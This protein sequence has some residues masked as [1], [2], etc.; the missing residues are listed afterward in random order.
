MSMPATSSVSR[1]TAT[2]L[3]PASSPSSSPASQSS[4][5][6]EQVELQLNA[7]ADYASFDKLP[8]KVQGLINQFLSD[9]SIPIFEGWYKILLD[10]KDRVFASSSKGTKKPQIIRL[11]Q[12][13][14]LLAFGVKHGLASKEFI[15]S[16]FAGLFDAKKKDESSGK[17]EAVYNKLVR[18]FK[19]QAQIASNFKNCAFDMS[20]VDDPSAGT[21]DKSQKIYPNEEKH[22]FAYL[23]RIK[24]VPF[25]SLF[26][27]HTSRIPIF[28]PQINFLR[29]WI[30][31]NLSEKN[32]T[33]ILSGMLGNNNLDQLL[34]NG[35]G[36]F[37]AIKAMLGNNE[38]NKA[39]LDMVRKII[40][41]PI[42][43]PVVAHIGKILA[44]IKDSKGKVYFSQFG[45]NNKGLWDADFREAY[46]KFVRDHAP[47]KLHIITKPHLQKL[48]QVARQQAQ[49]GVNS[50][51]TFLQR[52]STAWQA[53]HVGNFVTF[54]GT[55]DFVNYLKRLRIC[56]QEIANVLKNQPVNSINIEKLIQVLS[57]LRK[58]EAL[59]RPFLEYNFALLVPKKVLLVVLDHN[60]TPVGTVEKTTAIEDNWNKI[61]HLFNEEKQDVTNVH[62]KFL[63][64]KPG[65]VESAIE[66]LAISEVLK[67]ILQQA[68]KLRTL[69]KFKEIKQAI[70]RVPIKIQVINA[71]NKIEQLMG[72]VPN[73]Y[74][75]KLYD[76]ENANL[77]VQVVVQPDGKMTILLKKKW[78]GEKLQKIAAWESPAIG[79][80]WPSQNSF[81]ETFMQ[82]LKVPVGRLRVASPNQNEKVGIMLDSKLVCNGCTTISLPT[83]YHQLA[84]LQDNFLGPVITYSIFRGSQLEAV[85]TLP[86]RKA[87]L[88]LMPYLYTFGGVVLAGIGATT[89]FALLASGNHRYLLST[90]DYGERV[91]RYWT[92][93][94]NRNIAIACGIGTG[95]IL[96]VFGVLG[97]LSTRK[98]IQPQPQIVYRPTDKKTRQQTVSLF[99]KVGGDD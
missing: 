62:I 27:L 60:G 25:S 21:I 71:P 17:L 81:N 78:S 34:K 75:S 69:G 24:I 20:V 93:D 56:G 1:P 46:E 5:T 2:R 41:N 68:L 95:G 65:I 52:F 88:N 55:Y 35:K 83:F 82:A 87:P 14:A 51:K 49:K 31:Y 47:L 89:V 57:L 85:V 4:I 58:F 40:A 29:N 12:F 37:N 36:P 90:R 54:R 70:E 86:P 77:L 91:D 96:A 79:Q 18:F 28:P 73:S 67:N 3:V 19:Y 11:I 30:T 84:F 63:T 48:Y 76:H 99:N 45:A 64:F 7:N 39:K 8:Q 59:K 53:K 44:K 61:K 98:V 92:Y 32:V 13:L 97:L 16:L 74:Q 22:F 94:R 43:D 15:N 9:T 50:A 66:S 23:K 80:D 10:E 33:E 38:Q 72:S 6:V 42:Y 26:T